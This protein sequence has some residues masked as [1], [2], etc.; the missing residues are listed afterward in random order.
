MSI[1]WGFLFAMAISLAAWRLGSLS[2]SGAAAAVVLGTLVFGL[3]GLEWAILLVAFFVSSSGLSHLFKNRKQSLAGTFSKGAQRDAGQVLANGGCAG[4]AVLIHIVRPE[5]AWPWI[6]F[7]GILAAVNAD[8]WA[9]ELGVLSPTRPRLIT[10]LQPVER[11]TSGGISLV[12]TLASLAGALLIGLLSV[13]FRPGQAPLPLNAQANLP[14]GVLQFLAGWLIIGG[15]GLL[16]SLVDSLLGATLQ[17]IYYC[18]ACAKETEHHPLHTCD[19][20]TTLLRGLPW[21]DNDG[22]NA[23]CGLVGGLAALVFFL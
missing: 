5:L 21:L 14:P 20:P 7:S 23:A 13:L 15:A 12:G 16:G 1:L 3:G 4:L 11:G 8:T 19:T 17:T 2:R 10:T 18:P 6:A 22:V 9:T